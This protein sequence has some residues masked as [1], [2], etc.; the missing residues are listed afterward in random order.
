MQLM[1][2]DDLPLVRTD[3]GLLE[4]VLANLFANAL[5][6][7][8]PGRPPM[9]R[10]R[11]AGNGEQSV[12]LEIIDHGPGVP[13]ALKER[14]FEPFERLDASRREARATGNGVGLG[15]AVVKGFLDT[16][17]G[18]VDAADTP[19]GGLTIRVTLPAASAAGA[20][21]AADP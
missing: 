11:Q 9:L 6:Y 7:S 1:V 16:M 13:D 14:M 17:G 5:A 3:P 12:I 18:S 2:P 8:P 10:A 15:L 19:G 20:V 4:R 21:V